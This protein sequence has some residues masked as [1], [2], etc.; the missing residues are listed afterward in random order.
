MKNPYHALLM[1]I[2][3]AMQKELAAQIQYLKAELET[4]RETPG[5]N[6]GDSPW[7]ARA[8]TAWDHPLRC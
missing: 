7:Q 5:L 4:A 2:A 3:G 6:P 1:L 8:S